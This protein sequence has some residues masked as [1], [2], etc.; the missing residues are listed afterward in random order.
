MALEELEKDI[1]SLTEHISE[2]IKKHQIKNQ[3]P[4][5]YHNFEDPRYEEGKIRNKIICLLRN[6]MEVEE[7]IGK[8]ERKLKRKR[9]LLDLS[10]KG[11]DLDK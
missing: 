11:V 3:E 1:K 9:E 5:D 10:K 6:S 4:G 2:I 7:D 8:L